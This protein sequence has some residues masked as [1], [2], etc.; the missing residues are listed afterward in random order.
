M[1]IASDVIEMG[2]AKEL[3]LNTIKVEFV[4]DDASPQSMETEEYF[5][6]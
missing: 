2:A 5:D 1:Y 6:E 3:V 4:I